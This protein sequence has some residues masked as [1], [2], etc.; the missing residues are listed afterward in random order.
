MGFP[1]HSLSATFTCFRN[2]NSRF[3][4][5]IDLNNCQWL[6]SP[7]SFFCV[8]IGCSFRRFVPT[9]VHGSSGL[10]LTGF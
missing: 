7:G 10:E 4:Q 3:L 5:N 2:P 1:F 9:A 6:K 8:A